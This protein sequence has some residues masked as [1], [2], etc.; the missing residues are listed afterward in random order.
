MR[1]QRERDW[2]KVGAQWTQPGDVCKP[3]PGRG[4][5]KRKDM[6]AKAARTG[7]TSSFLAPADP[8]VLLVSVLLVSGRLRGL[9]R[10]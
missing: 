3:L 2:T 4:S 5:L 6:A 10:R 7:A 1:R 8:T 9:E